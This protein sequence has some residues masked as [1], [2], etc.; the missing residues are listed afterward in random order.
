MLLDS[1]ISHDHL[2]RALVVTRLITARRLTP[3]RHRITAAGS[4]SFTTAV[5]VIDRVHRD[6][7]HVRTNSFPTRSTGLAQRNV[8]M[9]DIAHLA[10]SRAAL[11]RHASNFPRR[12]AQLRV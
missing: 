5:R 10:H 3:G 4:F 11:N 12:H 7:A 8:F 9:L 2:L 1:P 6:A